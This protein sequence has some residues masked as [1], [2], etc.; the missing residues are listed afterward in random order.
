MD[1]AVIGPTSKESVEQWAAYHFAEHCE[2]IYRRT[3]RLFGVLM[4][5]QWVAAIGVALWISPRTWAGQYSQV[6]IH[7]WSAVFL[8]GAI[9]LFPVVL[10]WLRSGETCTR[11]VIAV[12]QMLMSALLIHLTGGRIETHFHIFVSI[13]FLAFYRDWKVLI[14]ATLVIAVDHYFRG[15]YYPQSVFGVV[16]ASPWRW[17]EHVGWMV[18]EDAVLLQACLQGV[19]EM[20]D[21]ARQRAELEVNQHRIEQKVRQRTAELEASKEE[22]HDA[23]DKAEASSQSKSTFLATMSHEIRTPLNGILGMTELV[24][25]TKLTSEQ[26][27][28]LDLVKL[29][30]ESLLTVINDILDFSKIEAGKLEFESLPFDLRENLGEMMKVLGFR[31]YQKGVELI[32]EVPPD[33]PESVL[34]D[35]G[36]LRQILVNLIGNAIKFTERGEIFASVVV[37]SRD[38]DRVCLHF[39]VRDTGVGI[40]AEKQA[41]IFDAFSQADGSMARKY[42]GTGLGLSICARLVRMMGGRIWVESRLGEGSTFHFTAWFTAQKQSSAS[43]GFIEPDRLRDLP[44]L[45]VDD[46]STNRRML[47]GILQQWGMRPAAADGGQAALAMIEAAAREMH[48]FVLVLLDSQMPGMDG[49]ALARKIREDSHLG[50]PALIMLTSAD[51]IGDAALCRQLDIYSYLVK[52]VRQSELIDKICRSLKLH[53]GPDPADSIS[54]LASFAAADGTRV[55]VAEDNVV[56]QRLILRLLEKRG[57]EVSIV[58]NGR[59]AL[60]LLEAQPFDLV[61]MDVQMP[62]MDGLQATSILRAKEQLTGGHLTIVAMTAHALKGDLE[63]CLDAGMDAY[64]SKPIR[65]EELDAVLNGVRGMR[66]AW[67]RTVPSPQQLTS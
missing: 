49:F 61:L 59:S 3:D 29:S 26:Q 40:R 50:D 5:I 35:P 13:A 20:K 47:T 52:P 36:R 44:V 55:L 23:K 27:E 2:A 16:L 48:P 7:V 57:F 38:A 62:E 37:K 31:A 32:Y 34:G 43:P 11:Y 4:L 18:F 12:S 8:G 10:A 53:G 24:L 22:L 17:M 65:T 64:L 63:R 30:A 41:G 60:A 45:V 9:T 21:I 67:T 33:V 25:G 42:G 1:K 66:P 19:R 56:N 6:H 51:Q 15:V 39:S 58:G 14:P 54:R 28:N 46:N